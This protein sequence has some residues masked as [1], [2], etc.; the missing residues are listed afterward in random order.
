MLVVPVRKSDEDGADDDDDAEAGLASSG[1]PFPLAPVLLLPEL[2]LLLLPL[3]L[4]SIS[5]LM[6]AGCGM[7]N[8]G[9]F[10]SGFAYEVKRTKMHFPRCFA[11]TNRVT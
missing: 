7:A 1:L 4:L 9:R 5:W 3:P 10:G 2:L 8:L 6:E 11:S